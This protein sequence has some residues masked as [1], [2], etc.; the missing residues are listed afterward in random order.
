MTHFYRIIGVCQS[1]Y[2]VSYFPV[3]NLPKHLYE[4]VE[5]TYYLTVS[6]KL[7]YL[8]KYSHSI[9]FIF[10]ISFQSYFSIANVVLSYAVAYILA[11]FIESPTLGMEKALIRG[12]KK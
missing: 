3:D 12:G 7:L 10:F 1:K 4:T 9:L 8:P 5:I 2:G 11:L 6:L